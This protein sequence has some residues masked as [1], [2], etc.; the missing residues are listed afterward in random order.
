VIISIWHGKCSGKLDKMALDLLIIDNPTNIQQVAL[1]IITA[2][3]H[4]G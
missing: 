3:C 2:A 1:I 4:G